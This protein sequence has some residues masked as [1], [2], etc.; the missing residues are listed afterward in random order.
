M[1]VDF[2]FDVMCPWAYQTSLWIREIRERHD[3]Q[4]NWRL[5][6]LEEINLVAGKKHPWERPISFGWTPLRV[7]AWL[8]RI[9]MDLCDAWYAAAGRALHI[10]GRLPHQADVA[11][12][13]LAEIGA[14][15]QAW[16]EALADLTTH[17]DV[18]ADHD[19]AVT[20]WGGFGV[21]MLVFP[22][23]RAVYGPVVAPA[24]TGA[25]ADAL[26]DLTVA[27]AKVPYLYEV[28][29]PKTDA[30]LAHIGRTFDPYLSN[31][32]WNTVQN[33]AR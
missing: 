17:D 11:A 22:W 29:T 24:P 10:E 18:R 4:V 6:S 12:E 9:D 16:D 30:D 26:W 7:A 25:D 23:G 5:F 19:E 13:L 20:R 31:R 28:K 21:P 3:V 27:Y 32:T 14:P 2:S 15:P 8:R 1:Q 33:P